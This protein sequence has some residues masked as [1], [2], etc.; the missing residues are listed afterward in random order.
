MKWSWSIGRIAGISV[1]VHATFPLLL[2]WVALRQGGGTAAAI[3]GVVAIL[4]VFT[5]VL[6]HE[7]GHALMAR[8]YGIGTHDITLLPI[9][10]LARLERMPRE[11]R[12]E[13]AIAV[14]GPAVNVALALLF[15][16]ILFTTQGV[17]SLE[18]LGVLLLP[19]QGLTL[20]GILAQ[21]VEINVGLILF[22]LLPAFPM[23]GGRVLRALLALRSGDL[24]RATRRAAQVGRV[25]AALFAFV[26]LFVWNN[27]S[28][29]LI[30]VFVWLAGAGEAASVETEAALE[31][32]TVA[33]L[34]ITDLRTVA[35]EATLAEVADLVIAGSQQDFPV[36]AEGRY[37][38]MVGRADLLRGLTALGP[39]ATVHTVMQQGGPSVALHE[40]P[41]TVLARLGESPT[42]AV[43]VLDGDRVVGILTAENLAEFMMLRRALS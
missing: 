18:A 17:R 5:I 30:A 3:A 27:P 15:G 19:S 28:L 25:F 7:F 41:A 4:V 43:P 2:L 36:V 9:G 14:A 26:G 10:G 40:T 31:R 22:N 37:L 42:R 29:V 6:L 8:R 32:T 23:D 11:P 13:L 16:G 24:A 21:L 35:P 39:Q 34:M 20:P 38:G 33:S 12:Q 1:R